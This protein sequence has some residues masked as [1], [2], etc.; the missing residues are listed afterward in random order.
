MAKP[1]YSQ[2]SLEET[3]WYHVVSRCVRRAYLCGVDGVSGKSYEHRRGWV[4]Q[5]LRKLASIFTIDIAA[6]AIMHNHY[7]IVLRVDEQQSAELSVE[8]VIHRWSQL[9]KGPILMQRYLSD[10]REH[11][12]EW[13]LEQ[14]T[15]LAEEYRQRLCDLSWFMRNLN[16]YISRKA[17]AEDK[18]KGHFWESRYKCQAL[19]DEQALLAAMAYVDLNP[20]RAAM[21]ETPEESRHTSI[22][23]RLQELLGEECDVEIAS[24]SAQAE[25]QH[26]VNRGVESLAQVPC[27]PLLGFAT[28]GE[29][30][31]IP[32]TLPDY[33]Q[34][35]DSV[36]RAVCPDKKGSISE[37]SPA[38]LQR[39]GINVAAFVEHSNQFFDYF[40]D[41]VGSA[42]RMMRLAAVRNV[43][44]LRGV[45]KARMVF[46]G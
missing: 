44:Y 39:L 8:E 7:H 18:A 35:L 33:L 38:I 3:P 31:S 13:E 43:R 34:L 24:L 41:S 15:K 11:M 40:G 25:E 6:Y 16:E 30:P 27:A 14:V 12:S 2:I 22:M 5:R 37:H 17:N 26:T 23:L 46:G 32:F 19:L 29:L 20:V 45:V 4:E 10:Q 36:G 28:N 9:Y 1:R 21:A 42:P